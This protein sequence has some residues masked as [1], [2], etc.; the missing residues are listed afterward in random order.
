MG[1][2]ETLITNIKSLKDDSDKKPYFTFLMGSRIGQIFPLDKPE[3]IVGRSDKCDLYIE[4]GAISR[5][6][7]KLSV[8]GLR[9][10]IEDLAST[11]GTYV[12]GEPIQKACLA[13]GDKIQI[14]QAT[15]L[16][17]T[18][19]DAT[20]VLSE[21]KRYELG[22]KDAVTG[23]YNRRYLLDRLREEFTYSQRRKSTLSLIMFDIDHF[24]NLNDTHGHLAGDLALQRLASEINE[25]IRSEDLFAR[26]GGEEFI[27]LL[28]DTDL[29]NAMDLADRLRI[30]VSKIKMNYGGV[31]FGL[32]I[33]CG[34]STF[35]PELK[36]ASQLIEEADQF[37]YEA[38]EAGRNC[39]KGP[40]KS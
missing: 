4:D 9:V 21:Q 11:N 29:K 12:N 3:I 10:W 13:D 40:L 32:T 20:R 36:E 37:L 1:N 34:V 24:K 39:V 22:V 18:Y 17:L 2:D 38:K 14:S 30:K 31:D 8:V 23:I 6:H 28:R 7:F 5:K 27:L 35:H 16:E 15:V 19:L 26:Y 25:T 33:S